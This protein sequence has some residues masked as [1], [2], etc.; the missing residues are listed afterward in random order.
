MRIK[1]PWKISEAKKLE[2]DIIHSADSAE[3]G[4]F[5]VLNENIDF[6]TGTEKIKRQMEAWIATSWNVT[7]IYLKYS[8]CFFGGIREEHPDYSRFIQR[9]N[10]IIKLLYKELR[11]RTYEEEEF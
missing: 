9:T 3:A 1:K 10:R 6:G 4:L 8:D 5:S 11:K 7:E 2:A